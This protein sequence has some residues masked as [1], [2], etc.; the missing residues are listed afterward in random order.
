MYQRVHRLLHS[1]MDV[2]IIQTSMIL[3]CS[4]ARFDTIGYS[5]PL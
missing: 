2:C 5:A 4:D 1:A 3:P